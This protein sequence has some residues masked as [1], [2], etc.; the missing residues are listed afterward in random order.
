EEIRLSFQH[1]ILATGS[2]PLAV[3]GLDLES[4]RVWDSTAALELREVPKRLLVVGG[5]YIGAELATVYAALGSKV[6]IVEL[7]EGLLPGADRD[8]V[9]PLLARM[10]RI[11][12]GLLFETKV[13]SMT[14]TKKGVRVTFEGKDAK[15]PEAEFDAVL[16]SVGRAP[17]TKDIGLET[18]RVQ[19]D[20]RGFVQVD[21][22]RRTAEPS[23]Y[24]IGDIAGQPMLAH[25]ANHE[26]RVAAESIAGRNVAFEPQAIPAVVFTDPEIAWTGLTETQAAAEGREVQVVRYPWAASGRAAALGRTDGVTKLVVDPESKRVLGAGIAGAGAGELI[27]EATHAIEMGALAED[28]ALTI[29]QHPTLSETLM[30]AAE[31][32]YGHAIEYYG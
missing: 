10:R 18:T 32:V 19:L 20:G 22:A 9:R 29:H 12:E 16:V 23:I 7:T 24:A 5:G 8:L 31:L 27:G 21:L 13:T 17:N 1:C 4:P 6:T 14:E 30:G 28:L 3:P 26:G 25:K 2:R 11:T 15:E